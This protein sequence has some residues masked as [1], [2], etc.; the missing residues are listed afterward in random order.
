MELKMGFRNVIK[1]GVLTLICVIA[2]GIQVQAQDKPIADSVN[3]KFTTASH[4]VD[5]PFEKYLNYIFLNARINGVNRWFLLDSGF[6]CSVLNSD[7]IEE[8]GL[9]AGKSHQVKSRGGDVKVSSVNDINIELPGLMIT[10]KTMEAIP[11]SALE[12]TVGRRIDGVLGYDIFR[13]LTI[14]IDYDLETLSIIRPDNFKYAGSGEIVPV[15]ISNNRAFI[16]AEILRAGQDSLTA[17]FMIDTGN[18]YAVYFNGSFIQGTRLVLPDQP[19]LQIGTVKNYITRLKGLKIGQTVLGNLIVGY[20]EDTLQGDHAGIIGSEVLRRFKVIFDNAGK[21][22]ILE[23]GQHFND[24]SEYDMSGIVPITDLIDFKSIK[25]SAVSENSPAS[26]A[27]LKAGDKI[28]S[29]NQKPVSG[30]D[31]AKLNEMLK[32]EGA[33]YSL[34]IMRDG[35]T[36]DVV[37][38]LRRWI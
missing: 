15:E 26:D 38:K 9:K 7:R 18:N 23:K 10:N 27:G 6:E 21:R 13:E 34:T 33:E 29:I 35:K 3:I 37:I 22:L 19:R 30:I 32:I 17:R 4:A 25:I 2:I 5:I 24:P 1:S 20:S 14:G 36:F 28:L 16:T 12:P 11:L 31:I 8:L